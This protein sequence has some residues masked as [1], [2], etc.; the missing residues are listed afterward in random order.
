MNL[1]NW[2]EALTL[3]SLPSELARYKPLLIR[4]TISILRKDGATEGSMQ[5]SGLK[6]Q[7]SGLK[8]RSQENPSQSSVQ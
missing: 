5:G 8:T 3:E 1:G 7:Q 4:G 2:R 6:P